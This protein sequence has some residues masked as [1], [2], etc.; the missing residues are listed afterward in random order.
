MS[1]SGR[2]AIMLFLGIVS[3]RLIWTGSFGWFVQQRMR[4]PLAVAAVVLVLLGAHELWRLWRAEGD[5][6]GHDEADDHA[7]HDD[8]DHAHAAGPT[9]GWMLLLP[10]LVLISV[11]PTGLGAAAA[12]RVDAFVPGDATRDFAPI[13]EGDDGEV[14]LGAAT[15]ARADVESTEDL[16]AAGPR[17]GDDG[18]DDS[19]AVE[20]RVYEFIDRAVWDANRSLEDRVI[21]LEGLVVND[22]ELPDGFRLTRFMVSCCAAD[23]IPLQVGVRDVGQSFPDDTWV[24]ADLVWRPPD[25]PYQEL[26][27]GSWV[28]EADAVVV[29]A[30][31][32]GQPKDPYE[33]PY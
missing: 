21:R 28:V 7:H 24:V 11:A 31:T 27:A 23:G 3:A 32:D 15:R 18:E 30:V 6:V 13:G 16:E 29:T 12:Q 9:V 20:M 25:T 19:Q 14:S 4:I 10:L 5:D 22:P 26:E 8:H 17:P 1:R 2:A 33:S